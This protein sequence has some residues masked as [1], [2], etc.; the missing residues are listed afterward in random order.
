MAALDSRMTL[1]R[2]RQELFSLMA[3]EGK[4]WAE[5]EMLLGRELFNAS[6]S[7]RDPSRNGGMQ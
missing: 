4:A 6:T 7:P 2:Y 5:V 3:E 1:N